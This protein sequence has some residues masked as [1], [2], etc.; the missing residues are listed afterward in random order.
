M[1]FDGY[2]L[3]TYTCTVRIITYPVSYCLWLDECRIQYSCHH[4]TLD[5]KKRSQGRWSSLRISQ[6]G[7]SGA[8]TFSSRTVALLPMAKS[9][10]LLSQSRGHTAPKSAP[11]P[12]PEACAVACLS[13]CCRK[14]AEG[15]PTSR[16]HLAP[17]KAAVCK[18]AALHAAIFVH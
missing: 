5:P 4:M 14:S 13:T 10:R 15:P 7:G 12:L 1:L 6:R 9:T 16:P 11:G 2:L 17:G 8:T 3:T 18:A